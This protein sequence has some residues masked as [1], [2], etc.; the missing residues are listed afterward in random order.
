MCE[1]EPLSVKSTV[2]SSDFSPVWSISLKPNGKASRDRCSPLSSSL[3]LSCYNVECVAP[4]S[5]CWSTS[6]D[7]GASGWAQWRRW[8]RWSL[9]SAAVCTG[10]VPPAHLCRYRHRDRENLRGC[11]RAGQT[12]N[13]TVTLVFRRQEDFKLYKSSVTLNVNN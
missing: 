6:A 8:T 7:R 12:E 11:Q 10:S 9:T 3:T 5:W 13:Q 2:F 1:L 4:C